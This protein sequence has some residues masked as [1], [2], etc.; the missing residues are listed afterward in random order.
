[1]L[2]CLLIFTSHAAAV[3]ARLGCSVIAPTLTAVCVIQPLRLACRHVAHAA[4]PPMLDRQ[5]QILGGSSSVLESIAMLRRQPPSPVCHGGAHTTTG[6][7]VILS[8]CSADAG[9][10]VSDASLLRLD[11]H[12][13]VRAAS[14]AD[15]GGVT[16]G[17]NATAKLLGYSRPLRRRTLTTRSRCYVRPPPPLPSQC[18]RCWRSLGSPLGD[19]SSCLGTLVLA[20]SCAMPVALAQRLSG[21]ALADLLVRNASHCQYLTACNGWKK[22]GAC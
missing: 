9:R 10:P 4:P 13:G 12:G 3:T 14:G 2:S 1:M 8:N 15:V 11:C 18:V 5:K 19:L 21:R 20:T 6:C 17:Y 22:A 7:L 16:R